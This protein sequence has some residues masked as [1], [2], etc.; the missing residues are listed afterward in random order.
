MK[1]NFYSIR[2]DN[3]ELYLEVN[4]FYNLVILIFGIL[5]SIFNFT[6]IYIIF[7]FKLYEQSVF[8]C[9]SMYASGGGLL[10]GFAHINFAI[11]NV[12]MV[13]KSILTYDLEVCRWKAVAETFSLH[14]FEISFVLQMISFMVMVGFPLPYRTYLNTNKAKTI[15][16]L[17]I[18]LWSTFGTTLLFFPK[19]IHGKQLEMCNSYSVW[20]H[21]YKLYHI[22]LAIILPAVSIPFTLITFGKFKNKTMSDHMKK[23]ILNMLN[24]LQF[25]FLLSW[26]LPNGMLILAKLFNFD[27]PTKGFIRDIFSMSMNL[28]IICNLPFALW[29]NKDLREHFFDIVLVKRLIGNRPVA[30]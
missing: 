10:L 18:V 4:T 27:S 30:V 2:N 24:W 8:N 6:K 15:S 3:N 1:L 13:D 23:D 22:V 28:T 12:L 29:K 16:F 11:F 20:T 9:M 25:F 14:M 26:C 17:L 21:Y 5:G 19:N 7:K